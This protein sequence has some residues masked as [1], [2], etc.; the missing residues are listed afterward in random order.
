MVITQLL[1]K[2]GSPDFEIRWTMCTAPPCLSP[3]TDNSY[4]ITILSTGGLLLYAVP[5]ISSTAMPLHMRAHARTHTHVQ[6]HY[7]Y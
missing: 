4:S 1:T 7:I 2:S 3:T 5:V 6:K